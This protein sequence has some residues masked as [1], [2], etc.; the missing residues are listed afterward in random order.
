VLTDCKLDVKITDSITPIAYGA[1][2]GG[3]LL[4]SRG[5]GATDPTFSMRFDSENELMLVVERLEELK[6]LIREQED[7]RKG[8]AA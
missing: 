5:G 2:P 3:A 7:A 4:F 1:Y 6:H 8:R